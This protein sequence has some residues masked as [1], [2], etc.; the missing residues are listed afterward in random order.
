MEPG[1]I[2]IE[3]DNLS[4]VDEVIEHGFGDACGP[5]LRCT[6]KPC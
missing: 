6:R 4:V 1:A 3:G 2:A 5:R